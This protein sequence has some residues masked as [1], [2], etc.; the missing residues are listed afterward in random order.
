M[1]PKDPEGILLY[2]IEELV[3]MVDSEL[4]ANDTMVKNRPTSEAYNQGIGSLAL[5]QLVNEKIIS[6]LEEY[7]AAAKARAATWTKL[8]S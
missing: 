1:K 5:A 7:N 3:K 6:I 8:I 4:T 2:G